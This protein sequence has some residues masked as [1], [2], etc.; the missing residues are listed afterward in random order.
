MKLFSSAKP[1]EGYTVL[2]KGSTPVAIPLPFED[3]GR[4][5]SKLFSSVCCEDGRTSD[6]QEA[7][8]VH[9]WTEGG[10]EPFFLHI[11]FLIAVAYFLAESNV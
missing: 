1:H 2:F 3:T 4:V 6:L 8:D 5:F 10:K 11:F 7:G 9:C